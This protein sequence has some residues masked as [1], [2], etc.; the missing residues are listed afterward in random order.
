MLRNKLQPE[1]YVNN[2]ILISFSP[3]SNNSPSVGFNILLQGFT[4]KRK[5]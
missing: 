1:M 2:F 3:G 4:L 5:L